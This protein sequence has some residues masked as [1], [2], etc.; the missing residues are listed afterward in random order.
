MRDF[1]NKYGVS[2]IGYYA[3]IRMP[4]IYIYGQEECYKLP[5]GWGEA[6]RGIKCIVQFYFLKKFL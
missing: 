1:L 6:N 3:A 5:L 4:N 2:I